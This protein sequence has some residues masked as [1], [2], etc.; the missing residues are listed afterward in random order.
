MSHTIFSTIARFFFSA[1][2]APTGEEMRQPA[3]IA[4]EGTGGTKRPPAPE[5]VEPATL[6]NATLEYL[7][8]RVLLSTSAPRVLTILADNRGQTTLTF[9]QPLDPTTVTTSNVRILTAGPDGLLDTPDDVSVPVNLQLSGKTLYITASLPAGTK[10]RVQ[11]LSGGVRGLNQKPLF[12]NTAIKGQGGDFD[13]ET[14]NFVF[15]AHFS[16]VAGAM[17]VVLTDNTPITNANFIRYANEAAWDNSFFQTNPTTPTGRKANFTLQAGAFKISNDQYDLVPKHAAIKNEFSNHNVLGTLAMSKDSTSPDSATNQWFFNLGNNQANLDSLNGG[18]TV[19]GAITDK[20]GL[21]V[22]NTLNS[23][24]VLNNAALL[25]SKNAT[26]AALNDPTH[27]LA[28]ALSQM[29]SISAT[30]IAQAGAL[31]P[32]TDSLIIYRVSMLMD[33]APTRLEGVRAV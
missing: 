25:N 5:P 1:A 30:K 12:G 19:F 7:E 17:N 6:E 31:D 33:T 2:G 21:K 20:N 8:G 18:S 28:N 15:I 16:T 11:L 32:L 10:Y 26:A 13:I 3:G 4:D 29:P 9:S 22:L 23:F 27:H 24:P 14:T